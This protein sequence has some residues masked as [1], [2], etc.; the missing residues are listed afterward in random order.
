MYF[1]LVGVGWL[2]GNW[3]MDDLCV[4]FLDMVLC[5]VMCLGRGA[6]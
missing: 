2:V 1:G 3:G 4:K 6:G 5:R